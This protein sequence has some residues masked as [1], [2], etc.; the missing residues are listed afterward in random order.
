[1][2]AASSTASAVSGEHLR[3]VVLD[4]RSKRGS[5]SVAL[6]FASLR[7]DSAVGFSPMSVQWSQSVVWR[8]EFA[9]RVQRIAGEEVARPFVAHRFDQEGEVIARVARPRPA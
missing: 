9:P 3:A 1:M 5:T 7:S 2:N 6:S 4:D 8:P